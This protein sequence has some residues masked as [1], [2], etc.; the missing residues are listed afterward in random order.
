MAM[1]EPKGSTE[2]K[3]LGHL[4]I[5]G[6]CYGTIYKFD[7]PTSRKQGIRFIVIYLSYNFG[8]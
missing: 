7:G 1:S 8:N 2:N 5:F 6:F 4:I 3:Y